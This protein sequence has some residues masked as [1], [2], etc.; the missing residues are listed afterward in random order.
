MLDES[1]QADPGCL[2]LQGM[3]RQS[4]DVIFNPNKQKTT[5]QSEW[6]III[7]KY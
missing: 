7:I 1:E 5:V 6:I 4:Q 3:K 2:V